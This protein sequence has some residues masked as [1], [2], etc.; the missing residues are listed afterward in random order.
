MSSLEL[1]TRLL[2]ALRSDDVLSLS[3]Q[4]VTL[5]VL[6]DQFDAL[7]A[8]HPELEQLMNLCVHFSDLAAQGEDTENVAQDIRILAGRILTRHTH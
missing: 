3:D 7:I 5:L 8:A 2:A 6:S 4:Y 1:P